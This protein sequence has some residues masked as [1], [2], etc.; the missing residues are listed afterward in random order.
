M[1]ADSNRLNTADD[2]IIYLA[3]LLQNGSEDW[4]L[5]GD[6][7]RVGHGPRGEGGAW[8]TPLDPPLRIRVCS[9]GY[10]LEGDR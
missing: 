9:S 5:N 10:R 3:F 8:P 7:G 6:E 2:W 1:H 4:I